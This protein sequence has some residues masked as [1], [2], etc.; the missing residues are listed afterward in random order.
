MTTII[1][2]NYKTEQ[3]TID[4]ITKELSKLADS[5]NVIVVNNAA[6]P[7]S[8]KLLCVSNLMI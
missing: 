4:Y 5:F 8:N 6:T 3:L 7:E 1:V 2:I